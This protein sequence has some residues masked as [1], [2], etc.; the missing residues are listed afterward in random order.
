[1][2]ENHSITPAER[3][4]ASRRRFLALAGTSVS[5]ATLAA[6]AGGGGG[7]SATGGAAVS[8]GGGTKSDTNP[9]GVKDDAA[10]DVVIFDGGYGDQYAKD[11]GVA[12]KKLHP[13]SDPQVTSTVNIQP[14]LQPRFIGGTPP[15]LFDNSGAQSLNTSALITEKRLATIDA[16]LKAPSVDGGTVEETLLPG[17]TSPGTYSGKFYALNYVYTVYALWYSASQFAEKGWSVPRTWDEVMS[18]GESA[19][20]AGLALF[21]WGG[22]NASN[23]YQELAITMAIKQGGEDVRKNLDKLDA[24]AFEQPAIVDAYKGIED[25][26]KAGYFLAGGAGI[27]HTEAQ[28]QWVSGKAVMYP[29]GSWIENEQR[30]ITPDGYQMTGIPVPTL[31]ADSKLPYEAIHSA[32]GEPFFVPADAKNGPGGLEF[33]RVML[34]K[35]QAQNFTKLTSSPTIVKDTIPDDAFGS[36]ALASTNAMIKAAG[37]DVFTFS[38][39]DWYNLGPD[40]VKLWTSFLNGDI[41]ADEVREKSQGLIDKIREDDKVEKFDVK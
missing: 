32:A 15:D 20:G 25:A 33:L 37:D 12:Y 21:P 2:N 40:T 27:K 23:Y 39:V 22:Q 14:D 18:L 24:K 8:D 31:A 7:D 16:L 11:A 34:S 38:F 41:G 3:L 19:K 29:S 26:V 28:S 6:C 1:M 9:F 10:V 30:G 35:E 13:K 36:T 17:V 5:A 4:G